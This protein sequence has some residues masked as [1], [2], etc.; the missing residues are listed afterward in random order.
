MRKT[1]FNTSVSLFQPSVKKV[2][3]FLVVELTNDALLPYHRGA[4]SRGLRHIP[5]DGRSALFALFV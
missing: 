3:N 2:F 4:G 1:F 5:R